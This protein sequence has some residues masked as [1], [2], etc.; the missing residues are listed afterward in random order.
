MLAELCYAPMGACIGN[1][2]YVSPRT[3]AESVSLQYHRPQQS[4]SIGVEYFPCNWIPINGS[5]E[6]KIQQGICELI[7][8]VALF[9]PAGVG[10]YRYWIFVYN[11]GLQW[12]PIIYSTIL[13]KKAT[14]TE[15][16]VSIVIE[17]KC[18]APRSWRFNKAS[19]NRILAELWSTPVAARSIGNAYLR[20]T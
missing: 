8:G 10:Q 15:S 7:I 6:L 3:P 2:F 14:Q 4:D 12:S 20:I 1:G 17:Y 9:D 11:L 13:P 18:I 19:A 16:C 5:M